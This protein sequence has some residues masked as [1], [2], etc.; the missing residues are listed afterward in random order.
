MRKYHARDLDSTRLARQASS[1]NSL[2]WK[3]N[4][5]YRKHSLDYATL[6]RAFRNCFSF[7]NIS[8]VFWNTIIVKTIR[9]WT[10][11][12]RE[13]T[14]KW[15]STINIL[16]TYFYFLTFSVH[17]HFLILRYCIITDYIHHSMIYLRRYSIFK[18]LMVSSWCWNV[19][20]FFYINYLWYTSFDMLYKMTPFDGKIFC[21]GSIFWLFW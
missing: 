12:S 1:T 8:R 20:H 16:H 18:K 5:G 15:I 9:S 17:S 19:V 6:W 4:V 14:Y 2:I 21:S 11:L 3:G 13:F 10:T 7:E